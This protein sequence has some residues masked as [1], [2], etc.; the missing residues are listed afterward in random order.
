MLDKPLV[1][2]VLKRDTQEVLEVV[3]K[4]DALK[5]GDIIKLI[6]GKYYII[7]GSQK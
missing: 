6:D 7:R 3:I 5:E 4:E 1:I 2:K